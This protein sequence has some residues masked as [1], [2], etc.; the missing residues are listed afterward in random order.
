VPFRSFDVYSPI[1][2]VSASSVLYVEFLGDCS[3]NTN[4]NICV[5]VTKNAGTLQ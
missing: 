5:S 2:C 1:L 4:D 3:Y